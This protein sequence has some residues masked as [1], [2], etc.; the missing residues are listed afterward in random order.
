MTTTK[1][2]SREEL[3][4]VIKDASNRSNFINLHTKSEYSKSK[5]KNKKKAVVKTCTLNASVNT[6]Y[7]AKLER[8]D[9]NNDEKRES[10]Y[11]RIN[12]FLYS[13]KSNDDKK[14]IKYFLNK[15]IDAQYLH[16]E[17]GNIYDNVKECA[18]E[19]DCM[20]ASFYK[21]FD[22]NQNPTNI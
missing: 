20:V 9:L 6:N 15:E 13:L 22:P 1:F 11:N 12:S 10:Y 18:K 4:N 7:Y 5:T 14:Y 19:N 3:L 17:S 21:P 2:V 16:V 8:L